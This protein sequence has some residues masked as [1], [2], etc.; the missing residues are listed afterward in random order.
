MNNSLPSLME[1]IL[2][3]FESIFKELR[4]LSLD[5]CP[6]IFCNK[7]KMSGSINL[8]LVKDLDNKSKKYQN[9]MVRKKF[10]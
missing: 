3:N 10:Q 2:E 4:F 6:L 9:K 8:V 1:T 7:V 5:L